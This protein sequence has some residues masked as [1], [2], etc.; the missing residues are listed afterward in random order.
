MG[1]LEDKAKDKGYLGRMAKYLMGEPKKKAKAKRSEGLPAS[2]GKHTKNL[3]K[4]VD[5]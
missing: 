3:L 4:M 2:L 1:A 5:A